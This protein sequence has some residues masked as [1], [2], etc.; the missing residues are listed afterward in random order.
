ML[1]VWQLQ[2]HI[3]IKLP[4]YPAIFLARLSVV[5]SINLCKIELSLL[6]Q[7]AQRVQ[8]LPDK[9]SERSSPD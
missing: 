9:T 1:V 4:T 3:S 8:K 5:A 2:D 6:S 7:K